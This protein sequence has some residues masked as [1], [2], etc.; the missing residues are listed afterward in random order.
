MS[1]TLECNCSLG[2]S[3]PHCMYSILYILWVCSLHNIERSTMCKTYLYRAYIGILC[4][5]SSC[6]SHCHLHQHHHESWILSLCFSSHLTRLWSGRLSHG[7]WRPASSLQGSIVAK[8]QNLYLIATTTIIASKNV[9]LHL[10]S[11]STPGLS[12][13]RQ[14]VKSVNLF[15]TLVTGQFEDIW[16]ENIKLIIFFNL[17]VTAGDNPGT[18]AGDPPAVPFPG[19]LGVWF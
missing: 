3:Q 15:R 9:S 1:H 19:D 5:Y 7:C 12:T 17:S 10:A 11:I 6:L 13:A 14:K 16:I 2:E 18:G 4:A 8:Y